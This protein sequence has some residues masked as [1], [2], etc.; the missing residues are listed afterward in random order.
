MAPSLLA[1]E[2]TRSFTEFFCWWRKSPLD[3]SRKK[4]VFLDPKEMRSVSR[5]LGGRRGRQTMLPGFHHSTHGDCPC[6]VTTWQQF[7]GAFKS[8][9]FSYGKIRS[10]NPKCFRRLNKWR[11]LQT[12]PPLKWAPAEILSEYGGSSGYPRFLICSGALDKRGLHGMF[13]ASMEKKNGM[14]LGDSQLPIANEMILQSG[15]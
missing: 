14:F 9:S 2:A 13:L 15:F 7:C 11:V 8:G 1:A 5:P 10:Q 4:K 3:F 12:V 6:K